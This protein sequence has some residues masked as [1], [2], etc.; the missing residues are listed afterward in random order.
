MD[1]RAGPASSCPAPGFSACARGFD[2]A[3]PS[4]V[5]RSRRDSSHQGSLR[6]DHRARRSHIER[7]PA[8]SDHDGI[9]LIS[10]L[11]KPALVAPA[12]IQPQAGADTGEKH[13]R[14]LRYPDE[15]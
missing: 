7:Q 3:A 4:P 10:A 15:I 11:L 12:V 1:T 2:E 13:G 6:R 5:R 9:T 8:T 14:W